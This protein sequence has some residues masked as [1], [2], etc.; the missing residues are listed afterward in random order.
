MRN[1]IED[2]EHLIIWCNKFTKEREELFK[3]IS[4]KV[5]YFTHLQDK[6]KLF[7][8]LNCE[9]FDIHVLNSLGS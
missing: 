5:K 2:E 8:I 7:W 4:S 9:E 3:L 1:E 6:H